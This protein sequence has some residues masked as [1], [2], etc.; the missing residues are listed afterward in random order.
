[1]SF[2]VALGG[3]LWAIFRHIDQKREA[4]RAKLVEAQKPFLELQ[5]KLY[6]EAAKIIGQLATIEN[7]DT[8]LPRWEVIKSR[9]WE[10]YWSEL[11]MVE[12][13]SV[14]KA[15]EDLGEA[16]N[17]FGADPRNETK[18]ATMKDRSYDV[19]RSLRNSIQANWTGSKRRGRL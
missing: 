11:T 15:M 2:L 7:P 17:A 5:L 9:F 12:D 8:E 1:V 3:G 19:A 10:L 4:V 13:D 6:V 18:R 14:E 16:L